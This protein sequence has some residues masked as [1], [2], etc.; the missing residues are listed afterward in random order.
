V[1]VCLKVG[2]LRDFVEEITQKYWDYLSIGTIAYGAKIK[3]DRVPVSA[4]CNSCGN[5]FYFDWRAEDKPCCTL[6]G[7]S[8]TRLLTGTELEVKEIL[9]SS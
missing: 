5:T 9:I 8:N 7:N 1:E 6:C 4:I 3:F 2:D